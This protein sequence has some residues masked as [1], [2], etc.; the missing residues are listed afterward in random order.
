MV[1]TVTLN[2]TASS[3]PRPL[4][5]WDDEKGMEVT[6]G[7]IFSIQNV[8]IGQTDVTSFLEFD[9]TSDFLNG[10]QYQCE[11]ANKAGTL[12]SELVTVIVGGT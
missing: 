9:V 1:E 12:A 7:G 6:D 10:T 2:C 8:S 5:T 11:A 4:I 3:L